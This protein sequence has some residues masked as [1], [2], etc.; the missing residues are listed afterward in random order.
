[1]R[2]ALRAEPLHGPASHAQARRS[3]AGACMNL[4]EGFG[5]SEGVEASAKL[6]RMRQRLAD[7]EGSEDPPTPPAPA[8]AA[9]RPSPARRASP[10][11]I[12]YTLEP[13]TSEAAAQ[14]ASPSAQPPQGAQSSTFQEEP[15]VTMLPEDC[16]ETL[17]PEG[18]VVQE[19]VMQDRRAAGT[20]F[21]PRL[22][23]AAPRMPPALPTPIQR[24]RLHVYGFQ[25]RLKQVKFEDE[26]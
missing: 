3:E 19:A 18:F 25:S 11:R 2:K 5:S 13:V 7:L 22:S 4:F 12:T 16:E 21:S 17:V 1:M 15:E 10:A 14:E 9:R 24:Q 26:S 8:P 6:Q 20:R 23:E